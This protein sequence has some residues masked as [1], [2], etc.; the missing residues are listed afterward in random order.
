MPE[1]PT[2]SKEEMADALRRSGYLIEYRIEDVLRAQGYHVS[3][4]TT[5]PDPITR[6]PRELDLSAIIGE[7]AGDPTKDWV[8]A[9]C[10]IECVNNPYPL[11]FLTKEPEIPT[12]HV[13]DIFVSG[14]PAHVRRKGG[15]SIAWSQWARVSE[16]LRME[17]YHHYCAGRVATQYCSFAPKRNTK[18]VEWM[19]WHEEGH[20]ESFGKLCAA[21]NHD[22]EEHFTNTMPR[23]YD[24]VNLEI[25]YPIV[26]VGGELLDVRLNAD[27]MEIE[28]VDQIHYIQSW[29]AGDRERRYHIDI[30]TERFFPELI[31]RIRNET[32]EFANRVKAKSAALRKSIDIIAKA[33]KANPEELQTIIRPRYL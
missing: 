15:K 17:E 1:L 26:V 8:F 23:L 33:A 5:Y 22:F 31:S 9:S 20:F 3:A 30:V 25:Y 13:Y 14:L 10:L 19:A 24:R 32:E 12:V 7:S 2:I 28:P 11:A 16:Y 21:L 6:K 29:I 4:N 18:P 27:P